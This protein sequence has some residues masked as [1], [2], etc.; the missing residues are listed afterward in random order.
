M[1]RC[2]YGIG[3]ASVQ[4]QKCCSEFTKL[5]AFQQVPLSRYGYAYMPATSQTRR[6]PAKPTHRSAVVCKQSNLST[7]KTL[8]A[9][10]K[11][12]APL[13]PKVTKEAIQFEPLP[14][15]DLRV[16]LQSLSLPRAFFQLPEWEVDFFLPFS[17]GIKSL[18]KDWVLRPAGFF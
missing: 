9:S 17:P 1:R 2:T 14:L 3:H 13:L 18:E 4:I 15:P 6:R 5:S 12:K 10:H 11:R 7:A 8:H 16:L